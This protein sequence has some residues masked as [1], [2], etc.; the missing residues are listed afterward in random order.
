MAT[1]IIVDAEGDVEG[2]VDGSSEVANRLVEE[3]EQTFEAQS[4]ETSIEVSEQAPEQPDVPPKFEGKSVDDIVNSYRN[5]EQQYGRQ[6]NELG[7]LRKLADSLIKQSINDTSQNAES[8]EKDITDSSNL[9]QDDFYADPTS[10]VRRIVNEALEPVR[11]SVSESKIDSTV[12]R[13]QA[14]HPD[15]EGIVADL[16]FQEWV[17]ESTP[18]QDMWVRAS[19]GNFDYADELFSQYKTTHKV[20]VEAKQ[21]QDNAVKSQE[22]EAASAVS[23]G[24]SKDAGATGKPVYKRAELIRL[25][26]NDPDRYNELHSE[27]TQAYLDGRVR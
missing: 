11:A 6:G 25:R 19:Q 22:L 20:A 23:S 8:I 24:S 27:I 3:R 12:Q 15:I 14:K 10:A 26:I 16:G 17:M 5:L 9:T 1:D 7:E 13:L 21:A 2:G 4:E 18:R